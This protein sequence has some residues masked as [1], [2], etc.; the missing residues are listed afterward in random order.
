[1][2]VSERV[3]LL[4]DS[5]PSDPSDPQSRRY[6]VRRGCV[7]L[8]FFEA[9]WTMRE[10]TEDQFHGHPTARVPARVLRAFRDQALIS[11]AE[12]RHLVKSL[13]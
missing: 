11:A 1:M 6:A 3:K 13:G 8:E 4:Q 12:Y 2:K 10:G 7:G 5:I 9:K